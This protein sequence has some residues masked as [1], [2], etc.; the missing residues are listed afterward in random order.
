MAVVSWNTPEAP[1]LALSVSSALANNVNQVGNSLNPSGY[2]YSAWEFDTKFHVSPSNGGSVEL[3]L[4]PSID[5]SNFADVGVA[6]TPPA[7]TFVGAFPLYPNA[8][9][10]MKVQLVNV[11]ISP[12]LVKPVIRNLSGQSIPASSGTLTVRLYSEKIV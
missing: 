4:V 11:P 2:L 10:G 5:G 7:T 8:N 12:L 3:Y 9:S 1:H 6:V